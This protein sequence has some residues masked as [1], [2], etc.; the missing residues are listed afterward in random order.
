[1]DKDDLI[2]R[3]ED[4]EVP[5]IELH[6]HKESLKHDLLTSKH[7]GEQPRA[8]I[9]RSSV[10]RLMGGAEMLRE[11]I[12][13]QPV[14]KMALISIL[15]LA[16]IAALSLT[17][18][19]FD[20]KS[21]M[22]LA[23]E[24]IARA[25]EAFEAACA[26]EGEIT[27]VKV[28]E[29]D[30]DQAVVTFATETGKKITFQ[31]D[32]K[33]ETLVKINQWVSVAAG[34]ID[35]S[36]VRDEAIGIAKTDPRVQ[37]LLTDEPMIEMGMRFPSDNE[38]VL[39]V[40]FWPGNLREQPVMG[41]AY[42]LEGVHARVDL[43]VKEVLSIDKGSIAIH[44][45]QIEYNLDETEKQEAIDIIAA[46]HRA[47]ELFNEGF[48]IENV[49]RLAA[50]FQRSVEVTLI[51]EDTQ[52]KTV[53]LGYHFRVDLDQKEISSAGEITLAQA[54]VTV[55]QIAIE[56]SETEREEALEIARS[57]SRVQEL[58]AN[59][60]IVEGVRL[61]HLSGQRLVDVRLKPADE[62]A[63]AVLI[64]GNY[65]LEGRYA[66]VDLEKKEVV[67]IDSYTW[68]YPAK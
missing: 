62:E 33:A 54:P 5:K 14:W 47:Q 6:G 31:V 3:L 23:A 34:G 9:L 42:L 4:L 32:L 17:V 26:G 41:G 45:A 63:N 55:V 15:A 38:N 46:D 16:L 1:M 28:V 27:L 49:R 8:T 25:S 22:A 59:G 60:F 61:L 66:R 30:N 65:M 50:D 20:G 44:V 35:S 37:E 13:R 57:D 64:D 24:Q 19:S 40:F 58:L 68:V 21:N 18:P 51:P 2:R 11:Y 7:W 53:V 52:G 48:I 56:F 10:S 29:E 67:A 36:A 43:E 39:D 12:A